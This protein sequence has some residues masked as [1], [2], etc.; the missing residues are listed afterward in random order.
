M[1]RS[2][3]PQQAPAKHT[4][5]NGHATATPGN[6]KGNGT[7]KSGYHQLR[8]GEKRTWTGLTIERRYTRAGIDPYDTV[9]WDTRE[10][11]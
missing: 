7:K 11:A 10:A 2:A 8:A 9:E 3:T 1:A 6:G 5:G 4:D